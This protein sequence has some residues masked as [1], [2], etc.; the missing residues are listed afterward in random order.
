M[1]K[2]K[3]LTKDPSAAYAASEEML[4]HLNIMWWSLICPLTSQPIL[5]QKIFDGL[6]EK[7]TLEEK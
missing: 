6:N 3:D 4:P 2:K 5:L 1:K 7:A